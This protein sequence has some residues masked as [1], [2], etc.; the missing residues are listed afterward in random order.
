MTN[1]RKKAD[2]GLLHVEVRF[3]VF[4]SMTGTFCR[5]RLFERS[6]DK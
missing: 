1:S 3:L 4:D 2:R 5:L 6:V